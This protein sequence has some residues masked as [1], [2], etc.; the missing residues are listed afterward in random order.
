VTQQVLAEKFEASPVDV[1][2]DFRIA[3]AQ[4]MFAGRPDQN[5]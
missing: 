5:G 4:A 2:N 3:A 1:F